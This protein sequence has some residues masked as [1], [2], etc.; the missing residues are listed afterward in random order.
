MF[1]RVDVG[2]GL[3]AVFCVICSFLKFVSDASGGHMME[4][5]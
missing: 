4:T 2:V 1:R 3:S 5:Y